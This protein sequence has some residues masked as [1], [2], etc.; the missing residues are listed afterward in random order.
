MNN[1]THSEG[2][3]MPQT[4]SKVTIKPNL[5]VPEPPM[6]KVI[7]MNDNHTTMEFVVTSLIE[8][9]NYTIDTATHITTGIHEEG[10][11]VVA[12]LPYE[13]AEQKGIEVTVQAREQGFPLQ[14]KVEA[15]A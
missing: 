14:I 5:R 2:K 4:D 15:E 9:F 6:F 10:S 1:R 11:A 3:T 7:Y 8:H 12:V 13:I